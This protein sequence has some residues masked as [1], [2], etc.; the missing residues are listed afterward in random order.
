VRVLHRRA[1]AWYRE[2]G[3]VGEAIGHITLAGDF[4]RAAELICEHW[5]ATVRG[6]RLATVLVWI[7]AFGADRL[8]RYPELSV[9][10]GLIVGVGGGLEADFRPWLQLAERG[11]AESGPSRRR[12]A[13]TSSLRSGVDLLRSGFGYHDVGAALVIA[14]RMV[15]AESEVDGQ[16][17]LIA[18]ANL[19]FLLYL[20][21]DLDGA[22]RALAGAHRD[23]MS[24]QRPYG[25]ILALAAAAL[26][27]LDDGDRQ[28][29]E[30]Y[31]RES[32]VYARAV[33]LLDNQVTGLAHV[34]LGRALLAAGQWQAAWAELDQS[35]QVF[36]SGIMDA[37]HV[38][39]LLWAAPLCQ[40][41][42]DDAAAFA[43]VDEAE[44]L[45]ARFTDAGTLTA[46]LADA[47]RRMT[48]A[49]RRR[50]VGPAELTE[51]ELSVLRQL[52]SPRSQREIAQDLAVSLN[53]VKTHSRAI[54]RKLGVSTRGDAVARARESGLI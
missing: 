38:Y 25:H 3:L 45:V 20:S 28:A 50:Q 32:L 16:F 26:V 4:D 34:A 21:G 30:R 44:T 11:L 35:V 27:A 19:G 51:A 39:A 24:T 42:G 7:E 13:G 46:L 37:W 40:R 33:G 2:Q 31:A 36:R 18:L 49:R 15:R 22:R 43:L 14:A 54:H 10:A 41:L 8:P 6:G 23:P 29:G 52:H 12:L 9:I 48:L 5:L 17:R 47:K 53:T 1:G